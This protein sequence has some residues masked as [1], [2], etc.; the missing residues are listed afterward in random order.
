MGWT[1]KMAKWQAPTSSQKEAML[2][3]ARDMM[4][5][6]VQ[7]MDRLERV[8]DRFEDPAAKKWELG[9][10]GDWVDQ[11]KQCVNHL[12]CRREGLSSSMWVCAGH[13]TRWMHVA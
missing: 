11:V 2:R 8:V 3:L 10:V 5:F 7:S 12:R 9:S 4:A 6:T 1:E 13:W